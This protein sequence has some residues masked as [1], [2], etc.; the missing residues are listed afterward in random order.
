MEDPEVLD[1]LFREAVSAMD[2]GDMATL[3]RLL[4]AHPRLVRDRLD[5]P[6]A[7]L[8][9][10]V[11]DGALDGFFRQPYLLWF[12]CEDPVRTGSL[13]R[14]IVEVTR[15]I[16]Q[17]AER[18]SVETLPEQLDYA[19]HL[20]VCSPVERESGLQIELIDALIDAGASPDHTLD[21]LVCRNLAAAAHLLERGAELT[22]PTAL[23]LGRW[24]DVARIAGTASAE[25]RQIALAAAAL[26]GKARALATL[27]DMGV[28]LDAYSSGFYTHATPLHHA[29]CSGS[30]D[31][32]QVL[33]E[34][35][36]ALG[37]K[38]KANQATPL[39]WAEYYEG[40][41]ARD[42]RAGQYAEIAA[43]LRE[44]EAHP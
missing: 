35:G 20:A 19:I 10:M 21:C 13:P 17:A 2:A 22:L 31:A 42:E 9:D 14:N 25:E 40:Q 1:S 36:A 38:D 11:G 6:G 27:I 24:D 30:L 33:V 18:Q 39:G 43:Y 28:D 23:C 26:N 44:K 37:T 5:A 15:T 3:E 7:W 29:V 41:G 4:V 16:L 34:A 32:V 8:R 12:V